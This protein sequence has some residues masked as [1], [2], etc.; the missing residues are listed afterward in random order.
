MTEPNKIHRPCPHCDRDDGAPLT[1]YGDDGWDVVQ[2]RGCAFVYLSAGLD[3]AALADRHAWQKSRRAEAER[4]RRQRPLSYPLS[5]ATR[6]RLHLFR[7]D[8]KAFLRRVLPPGNV[9][10]VGCGVGRRV[11]DGFTPFGIEISSQL[12]A[13]AD[14]RFRPLGGRAER[15]PALAGLRTFADGF[16]AGVIM[17]SYL[18]HESRPREV[19][20]A[21]F[22]KL[23]GDGVIYVKVPNYGC[24]NR[25]LSGRNWPGFRLPDHLNYFTHDSLKT[26]AEGQGYR[27]RA[28]N[29][30][31]G[32]L[33]NDNI[34]ALLTK[35]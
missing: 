33:A 21:T 23:K 26:M 35:P 31:F 12:C 2:C 17:R 29:T 9:L 14:A 28:L 1:R 34:H 8:E 4:R 7:R 20:G 6:F 16:F 15:A 11:P 10:D 27:Y 22:P 19:L 18:E 32:R 5:K 30:A 24:L 13:E 25:R 3:Y